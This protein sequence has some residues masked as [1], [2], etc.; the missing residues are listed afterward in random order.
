MAKVVVENVNVEMNDEM[1]PML[2]GE[3]EMKRLVKKLP[4]WGKEVRRMMAKR[5]KGYKYW[6]DGVRIDEDFYLMRKEGDKQ[7]FLEYL[8][9]RICGKGKST[10]FR[11]V[12]KKAYC[13]DSIGRIG[14]YE[15][16]DVLGGEIK[17]YGI[18]YHHPYW[19]KKSIKMAAGGGDVSEALKYSKL[20]DIYQKMID[21]RLEELLM[22]SGMYIQ[23]PQM[24]F[25][26]KMEN[27]DLRDTLIRRLMIMFKN[28]EFQE[29]KDWINIIRL[30]VKHKFPLFD[31]N[32]GFSSY[33]MNN[34]WDYIRGIRMLGKDWRNPHYICPDNIKDAHD[35]I[36]VKLRKKFPAP[37]D[38]ED[39]KKFNRLKRR[40]VGMVF[41]E[42]DLTI[43]TLD[44]P[45]AYIEE[46]RAMHN[47][48]ETFKY[49]LKPGSLILCA[50]LNG[51]RIADIE[52]SLRDYRIIQ[53]CG[54]CN[55]IVP[56]RNEIKAL[57]DKNISEIESRQF[58]GKK[59]KDINS[60]A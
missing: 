39:K 54:P 25:I 28:E 19:Y 7:W 30:C 3:E 48:I 51:K 10:R 20:A 18:V 32:V 44:S 55:G 45:Q 37:V 42:G 29:L 4:D 21:I 34:W 41:E 22:Y 1:M 38:K 58:I 15:N 26:Y 8:H 16:K 35:R 33:D 49:Y 9:Y 12:L 46:S 59:K 27:Q 43:M 23:F 2:I 31:K 6:R 17:E 52:L 5:Y 60:A 13:V 53:C 56:E 36:I 57:I 24:E 14:K 11:T 47:C 40:Y 50:R